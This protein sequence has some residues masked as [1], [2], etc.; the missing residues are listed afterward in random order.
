MG[1]AQVG[2]VA[3][4]ALGLARGM[5]RHPFRIDAQRNRFGDERG[6]PSLGGAPA[7]DRVVLGQVQASV[8]MPERGE[9]LD[10]RAHRVGE[11]G[12]RQPDRRACIARG[13]R[14][15]VHAMG[16][17]RIELVAHLAL[18]PLRLGLPARHGLQARGALQRHRLGEA[19]VEHQ[20]SLVDLQR[21]RD[22]RSAGT[23][24][25]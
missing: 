6:L 10:A 11:L 25:C 19:A 12:H 15:E 20:R 5:Q 18:G 16:E 9:M 24:S 23:R 22:R 13:G 17:Q 3:P 1:L 14:R 7:G 21:D 4:A 8:G 2:A